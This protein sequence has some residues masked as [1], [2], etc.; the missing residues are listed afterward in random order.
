[1]NLN[2]AA[3]AHIVWKEKL[4]GYLL[5]RDES[6]DPSELSRDDKCPLGQW[7]LGAGQQYASH[8]EFAA[9]R[10]QHT[11][12]HKAV[13]D[14]VR[15]ARLGLSIKPEILLDADSEFGG[16]SVAV[17]TAII[18]LKRKA[19]Q[20]KV[21]TAGVTSKID[22]SKRMAARSKD[23]RQIHETVDWDPSYTVGVVQLDEHH[24]FFIALINIVV[25]AL[26]N[27][28]QRSTTGI[29]LRQ[30]REFAE[31]HFA[32]E[33]KLMTQTAYP[34]LAQHRRE[35]E[36]FMAR[37]VE[38]EREFEADSG[39]DVAKVLVFLRSWLFRHMRQIDKKYS[40]HLHAGGIH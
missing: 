21:K 31:N 10:A 3:I 4:L 27:G 12:F 7:I 30:L 29:V 39:L 40:S 34:F 32:V 28:G 24:Q 35:H 23:T 26:R 18:G 17:V 9:L 36:R 37:L 11:R 14:V 8:P 13:G 25:E 16:A 38:L 22:G 6:L 5:K 1:M 15:G 20:A 19:A 33:E 2:D